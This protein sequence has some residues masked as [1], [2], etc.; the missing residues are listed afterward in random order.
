[1]LTMFKASEPATPTEP[2]PAP[3]EAS[4]EKLAAALV[5]AERETPTAETVPEIDASERTFAS[6][7]ATPTPTFALPPPVAE[8]S[9]FEVAVTVAAEL[10]ESAPAAVITVAAGT[11]ARTNVSVTLSA[12]AAPTETGPPEVEAL[13]GLAAEPPPPFAE[14]VE[15][16][17]DRSPAICESTLPPAESGAPFAPASASADVVTT[18][19]ALN[20]TAPAEISDRSDHASE[21]GFANVIATATPIETEPAAAPSAFVAADAVVDAVAASEPTDVAGPPASV[22]ADRTLEMA[23]A[24]AGAIETP[25]PVAPAFASVV[26]AC[27]AEAFSE[28]APP[29]RS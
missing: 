23:T 1:M 27:D 4:A 9:A 21:V 6:V 26:I 15:D 14:L 19:A 7:I 28:T 10:S 3:E 2:P 13:G 11:S 17:N 24:T 25:A 20:E 5:D 29:F 16:A 22:A 18:A 8:P 12:T